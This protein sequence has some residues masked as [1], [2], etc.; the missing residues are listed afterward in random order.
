MLMDEWEAAALRQLKS[1]VAS[2]P[3]G[4]QAFAVEFREDLGVGPSALGRNLNGEPKMSLRTYF[5]LIRALG[6]TPETY[7]A[8]IRQRVQAD[9]HAR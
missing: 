6:Y 4:V 5:A 8:R 1:D 2:Y 9:R 3:G 7:E